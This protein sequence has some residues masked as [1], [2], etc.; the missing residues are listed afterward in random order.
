M[1]IEIH[2]RVDGLNY[3][4]RGV[5]VG[6]AVIQATARRANGRVL[7]SQPHNIQ[8][9]AP[10]QLL[11]KVV[12]LLPECSFQVRFNLHY[13]ALCFNNCLQYG[14]AYTLN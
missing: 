11:P 10:L 1:L 6:V 7:Q 8:V 4:L 2:S 13:S 9:F 3:D 12:T 5:T 14:L